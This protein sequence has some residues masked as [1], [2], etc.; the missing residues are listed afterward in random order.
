M[1]FRRNSPKVLVIGLDC[2]SPR[3]LFEDFREDLPNLK[4]M[5]DSGY[6]APLR[7]IHPPITIPAWMSMCTGKDAGRL[8][9]YGFRARRDNS[10]TEFDLSTS[11]DFSGAKKIW[12]VLAE[13]DKR[14]ILIGI[15]PTY[16]VYPVKGEMISGFIC[17][18]SQRQYTYPASLKK[19]IE[20]LIGEYAFDVA[21]RT[22]DRE[23]L[24]KQ[25]FQMTERRSRVIEY[26][27][28]NK[29]W[30]FFMF[31]EIGVDRIQHAFWKY[32]DT[33]HHLYQPNHR[34]K[35]AILDYYKLIDK[36]IGRLLSIL[37]KNTTVLVVSDHG[38]KAMKGAFCLNEW[39]IEK[40][41]L[42]LN[43]YPEKIVPF[44][45]LGINWSKTRA[46]GW[47]GYYGRIFINKKG[48]ETKGIV[49]ESEY[50]SLRSELIQG[51]KEVRSE[52]GLAWQ[53]QVYRPEE[54]YKDPQG[55]L[56][57]LMAYFDDLSYRSAGTVGHKKLFL[58]ENDT[59]P[60]D[61]VHDWD[62]VFIK[63]NRSNSKD[64]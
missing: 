47:G 39:L 22:D 18:D 32:Y 3:L 35:N 42:I 30:D 19:E 21:F 5:M 26:L 57:D 28:K 6:Y 43:K 53:T 60:D 41:Y 25:A 34:Y 13:K 52:T 12:D 40:G 55:K 62:G 64:N 20:K 10:Y 24:L 59:G 14:N 54:L 61:A 31:V 7:S 15:P 45:N 56:A 37:D 29:K 63:Y 38:A 2:A 27:I 50:E 46:W 9:V 48:R 44:E 4:R 11:A 23:Q 17:P 36:N 51:L 16:P 8:G 49:G 33:K 58:G 1:L